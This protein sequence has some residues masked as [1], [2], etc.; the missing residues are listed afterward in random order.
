MWF[1]LHLLGPSAENKETELPP[2]YQPG[3]SL[4]Q[5][6]TAPDDLLTQLSHSLGVHPTVPTHPAYS[7]GHAQPP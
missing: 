7:M 2:L 5:Q 1:G 6:Q 4:F 3:V